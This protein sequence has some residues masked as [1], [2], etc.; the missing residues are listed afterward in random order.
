[1]EIMWDPNLLDSRLNIELLILTY[2]GF[3]LIIL[4]CPSIWRI[5]RRTNFLSTKTFT[6]NIYASATYNLTLGLFSSIF[7]LLMNEGEMILSSVRV[8]FYGV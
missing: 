5:S 2:F 7:N 1:M 3:L 4:I 6:Y 8:I